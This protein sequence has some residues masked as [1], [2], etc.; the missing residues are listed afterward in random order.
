MNRAHKLCRVDSNHKTKASVR[1]M[2]RDFLKPVNDASDDQQPTS[3]LSE[4]VENVYLLWA[5][6]YGEKF[7]LARRAFNEALV[8]KGI[9]QDRR[10]V[11][12]E[13]TR[14]WVGLEL[15]PLA[16]AKLSKGGRQESF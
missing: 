9:K 2:A 13:V 6:E 1:D 5:K 4:F 3:R 11:D 10:R 7:P 15:K 12:G 16:S 8:G 14:I